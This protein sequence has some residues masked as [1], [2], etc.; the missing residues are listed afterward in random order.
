MDPATLAGIG[1][2]LGGI[3][4]VGG[5]FGG[6]SKSALRAQENMNAM[7]IQMQKEFAQ[8]GI[9][10]RVEDAK[11]AGIHP[12]YA[13]GANTT[14]FSPTSYIPGDSGPRRDYGGALEGLGRAGQG[15][16]RA[17]QAKQSEEERIDSKLNALALERGEL[18]NDLLRSQIAR[19]NQQ[20][21]PAMPSLKPQMIPGQ[22]DIEKLGL[23][24]TPSQQHVI[25]KAQEVTKT[26][27]G[28][29]WQ[30]PH[31]ISDLGFART[32]SG[33]VPVPSKDMKERIEDMMVPETL[34][35]LRNTLLPDYSKSPP[36]SLLPPGAEKWTYNILKGEWQPVYEGGR[37]RD[38]V[39][40]DRGYDRVFDWGGITIDRERR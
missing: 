26:H 16:A 30:E 18:E 37:T 29:P 39:L 17:L 5:L 13:L 23:V 28:A 36:A 32:S 34:W 33:L 21:T 24:I 35:A 40:R 12:L 31:E 22:S 4:S 6:S 27:P 20:P 14:S 11:A 7:N 9:R 3:G 2:V 8:H 25:E 38:D 10:W 15:L 1:S 19:L